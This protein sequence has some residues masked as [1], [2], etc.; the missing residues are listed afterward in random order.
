MTPYKGSRSQVRWLPSTCEASEANHLR[1][2]ILR[3]TGLKQRIR[4]DRSSKTRKSKV[5]LAFYEGA[6]ETSWQS[7]TAIEVKRFNP[8][9][10]FYMPGAGYAY[11]MDL[12]G[13]V[14]YCHILRRNTH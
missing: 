13:Y 6:I 5:D 11:L 7:Q 14:L 4:V 1:K 3:A 10:V 2:E 9:F 12:H 8:R